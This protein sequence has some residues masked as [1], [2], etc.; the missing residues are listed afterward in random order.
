M[1]FPILFSNG[2]SI[3]AINGM[4]DGTVQVHFTSDGCHAKCAAINCE[5]GST[6]QA[7][8]ARMIG[9]AGSNYEDRL[10]LREAAAKV[11][12]L[13]PQIIDIEDLKLLGIV[14]DGVSVVEVSG[15]CE[16]HGEARHYTLPPVVVNS[17][18]GL[19]YETAK[20]LVLADIMYTAKG[21]QRDPEIIAVGLSK[22]TTARL[23]QALD[24]FQNPP[25]TTI[26]ITEVEVGPSRYTP[27]GCKRGD[28]EIQLTHIE[29]D[30]TKRYYKQAVYYGFHSFEELKT[31][32]EKAVRSDHV[33][34]EERS[35]EF[36]K[37]TYELLGLGG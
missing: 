36:L 34:F 31:K 17:F 37:D 25:P 19:C 1:T 2:S 10:K 21:N 18:E 29:K 27:D 7:D 16:L 6:T 33:V 8:I 12:Q 28:V 14:V 13:R 35:E 3:N 32:L 26:R 9:V 23:K 5:G 30:G 4:E 22:S 15:R 24:D 11:N 20:N